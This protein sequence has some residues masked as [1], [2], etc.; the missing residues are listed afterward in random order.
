MTRFFHLWLILL[1]AFSSSFSQNQGLVKKSRQPPKSARSVLPPPKIDVLN[2]PIPG[3]SKGINLGNGFDAPSEGEWGV[4]IEE[5]HFKYSAANGFDYVRLPIRFSAYAM[6]K[7]PFTIEEKFFKK[8]DWAINMALK[9]KLSIIVDLHH[10]EEIMKDPSE[11]H[12]KRF[13]AMWAQIAERYK[14]QPPQVAFELINEPCDK[15][16]PSILNPLLEKTFKL[17]RKTNPSR[18]IIVEGYFWSATTYLDSIDVSYMDSNTIVTFH[19]YQP[20]LFTHQGA[21]WMPIDFQTRGIQYPGPPEKPVEPISEKVADW[22][23]NWIKDYNTLP[24]AQNPSG[25]KTLYEEFDRATAFI[26]R[27]GLRTL[28]GEFGAVDLADETSR[29]RFLSAVRIESERR[30]IPWCYWDDGGRN[31]GLIIESGKMVPV[32]KKSLFGR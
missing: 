17:V 29:L 15:L 16:V 1:F 8:I 10:Y 20:I 23:K 25:P 26:K 18:L 27:T 3:F 4:I 32:V 2:K 30:G 7:A 28:L 9:Y 22:V 12:Q 24:A 5:N 14:D 31:K 19:M 21:S 6:E 13:M 11:H